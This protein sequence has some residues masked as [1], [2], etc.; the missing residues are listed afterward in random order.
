M[1]LCGLCV[2]RLRGWSALGAANNPGE[3]FLLPLARVAPGNRIDYDPKIEGPDAVLVPRA[4]TTPRRL[5]ITLRTGKPQNEAKSGG[6]LFGTLYSDPARLRSFLSG[7]TGAPKPGQ[8]FLPYARWAK[9]HMWAAQKANQFNF[10]HNGY[11]PIY[12]LHLGLQIA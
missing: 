6:S 2:L 4:G 9:H 8:E 1:R 7:M 5:P 12:C 11:L 10:L 3:A